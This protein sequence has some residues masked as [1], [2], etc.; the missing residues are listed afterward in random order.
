MKVG[1]FERNSE[2]VGCLIDLTDLSSVD[3]SN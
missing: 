2:F 1:S 3:S